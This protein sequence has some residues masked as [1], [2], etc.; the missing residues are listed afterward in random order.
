MGHKNR[1]MEKYLIKPRIEI[2]TVQGF[3]GPPLR[4]IIECRDQSKCPG[5]FFSEKISVNVLV[6]SRRH[7]PRSPEAPKQDNMRQCPVK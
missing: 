3:L 1:A 2:R 6:L 5:T 7:E 4:K